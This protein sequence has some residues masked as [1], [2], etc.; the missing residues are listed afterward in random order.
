VHSGIHVIPFSDPGKN[1]AF[2]DGYLRE[3][4]PIQFNRATRGGSLL[5]SAAEQDDLLLQ[6]EGRKLGLQLLESDR[7]GQMRALAG[8]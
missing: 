3:S 8:L 6:G 7:T 5:R 1:P 2:D 4:T